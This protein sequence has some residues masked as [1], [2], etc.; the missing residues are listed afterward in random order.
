MPAPSDIDIP[1]EAAAVA[2]QYRRVERPISGAVAV[3][4]ALIVVAAVLWLPFLQAVVV[5]VVA[6]AAVRVPV[7]RS[8]GSARLATDEDPD[9]VRADFE[10]PTPPPLALQ[11]GIA[12]AVRR[13]DGGAAYEVS[14]LFGLRSTHLVVETNAVGSDGR[15][16]ELV[17]TA[18]GRPWGT[19]TVSITAADGGTTVD[20]DLRSDRRFGLRRLPQWLAAERYRVAALAAQG[21]TVVERDV[22]LSV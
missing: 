5:A 21:Y 14:Y 3:L 17:V 9:T 13:T 22:G 18:N 7:F 1:P 6:L 19:Y 10:G 20:V 8:N 2:T 11:W 16:L 12:D 15:R 4:V